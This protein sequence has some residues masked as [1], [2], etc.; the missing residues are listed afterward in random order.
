MGKF[1]I[2]LPYASGKGL[3]HRFYLGFEYKP[4]ERDS[5]LDLRNVQ[6]LKKTNIC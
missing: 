3:L 5:G 2:C 1:I 6:N 4:R